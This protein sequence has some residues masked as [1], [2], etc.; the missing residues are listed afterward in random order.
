[1][2]PWN[3][4][5]IVRQIGLS[6]T[7]RRPALESTHT[8]RARKMESSHRGRRCSEARAGEEAAGG[9]YVGRPA[10]RAES[11]RRNQPVDDVMTRWAGD[12]EPGVRRGDAVLLAGLDPVIRAGLLAREQQLVAAAGALVHDVEKAG[13]ISAKPKPQAIARSEHEPGSITSQIPFATRSSVI[14]MR[15][16]R[17]AG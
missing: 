4:R 12:A 5:E 3:A 10:L 9:R 15:W 11:H 7:S 16:V 13:E 6:E 17:R 14:S 2:E 1:M 8:P